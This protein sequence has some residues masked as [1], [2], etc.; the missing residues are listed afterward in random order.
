MRTCSFLS[1]STTHHSYLLYLP[2]TWMLIATAHPRHDD[3]KASSRLR[4]ITAAQRKCS[5]SWLFC[6][7]SLKRFLDGDGGTA[8]A[9]SVWTWRL[10]EEE[11]GRQTHHRHEVTW[12]ICMKSG[13]FCCALTVRS[14]NSRIQSLKTKLFE[15]LTFSAHW[16]TVVC[17]CGDISNG[18]PWHA[19]HSVSSVPLLHVPIFKLNNMDDVPLDEVMCT[20]KLH[21]EVVDWH[22]GD[23]GEILIRCSF[24]LLG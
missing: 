18:V 10:Q 23:P 6:A 13:T 11:Q 16:H 20:L 4:N 2:H 7:A 15:N 14:S 3:H 9:H 24:W 17:I 12:R 22:P 19:N 5:S 1:H 21:V 8:S